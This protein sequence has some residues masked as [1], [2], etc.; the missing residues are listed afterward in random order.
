M[1]SPYRAC[2]EVGG[3]LVTL[4]L[5]CAVLRIQVVDHGP[6][7]PVSG[8]LCS[9]EAL[10]EGCNALALAPVSVILI[11]LARTCSV[12]SAL[13]TDPIGLGAVLLIEARAFCPAAVSRLL[14]RGAIFTIQTGLL[15][16]GAFGLAACLRFP[17]GR[18]ASSL[19]RVTPDASLVAC[20]A[21][22]A[23]T[24][25]D[26]LLALPF[27]QSFPTAFAFQLCLTARPAIGRLLCRQSVGL[28][29]ATL[30]ATKLG[31]VDF[32][33]SLA[34]ERIE[35]GITFGPCLKDA[36]VGSPEA[37]GLRGSGGQEDAIIQPSL[38]GGRLTCR[39]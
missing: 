20:R 7:V 36:S 16:L 35:I 37:T 5:V 11:V 24:I 2:C 4:P 14:T 26:R 6:A 18:F 25:G 29:A 13:A 32:T 28:L 38:S 15:A 23:S 10:F 27:H 33:L 3:R 17:T 30:V 31:L 1:L 21:F 8:S 34:V 9:S 12:G 22:C 39:Q 19:V